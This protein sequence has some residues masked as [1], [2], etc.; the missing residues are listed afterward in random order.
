MA[1]SDEDTLP[2]E[3]TSERRRARMV[4]LQVLYEL[5]AT[6][7]DP[8]VVLERRLLEDQTPSAA[9]AYVRRLIHAVRAHQPELDAHITQA[10]PAWPLAQMS[11]VDKGVLRLAICEMLYQEDVPPKVAINEA[12]EL[13]KLF[14]HETSPKFVN[15][16]LGTIE[17]VHRLL[18]AAA[19]ASPVP[20]SSV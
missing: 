7:H 9:A 11:L 2:V 1:D 20:T 6:R 5:D 10:A 3:A 13:A 18:P 4:A 14:G 17:R 12:V 15:G 8:D 16:V 19:P